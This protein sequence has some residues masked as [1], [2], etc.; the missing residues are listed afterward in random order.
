MLLQSRIKGGFNCNVDIWA[1]ITAFVILNPCCCSDVVVLLTPQLVTSL[2]IYGPICS[3]LKFRLD[4]IN[5]L[6]IY[7]FNWYEVTLSFTV[8]VLLKFN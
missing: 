2:E 5:V 6:F 3:Y 8:T 1:V 7:F 4:Y